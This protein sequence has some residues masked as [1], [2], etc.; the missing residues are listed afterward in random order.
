M[1][2]MLNLAGF[3]MAAW[4]PASHDPTMPYRYRTTQVAVF[5]R[6]LKELAAHDASRRNN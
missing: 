3:G 1:L 4:D 6:N 2:S 5:D